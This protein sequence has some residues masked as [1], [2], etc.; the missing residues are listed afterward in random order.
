MIFGVLILKG[1]TARVCIETELTLVYTKN[2]KISQTIDEDVGNRSSIPVCISW[3]VCSRLSKVE[4]YLRK[5]VLSDI[6]F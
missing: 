6:N 1:T 2:V 5:P 3:R 4:E